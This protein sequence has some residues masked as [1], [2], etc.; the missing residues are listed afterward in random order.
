MRITEH[1]FVKEMVRKN[2][3]AL[4]YL[5]NHYGGNIKSMVYQMMAG[6]KDGQED[7]LN[8]VF[9]SIWQNIGHYDPKRAGVYTWLMAVTRYQTLK[10]IRDHSNSWNECELEEG[11][12]ITGD[13]DVETHIWDRE[14]F[15]ALI[16]DLSEEDQMIFRELFWNESSYETVSE[17]TGIPVS[18]LYTRVFRGKK[19]IQHNI[20]AGG[21]YD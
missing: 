4:V 15:E 12:E 16:S 2:E 7:C 13:E 17:Q 3:D 9:L 11:M 19:R 6:W 18:R 21:K 20:V 10:Y 14:N 8:E 1:N 5:M